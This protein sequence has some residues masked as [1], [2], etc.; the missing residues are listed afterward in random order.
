[1]PPTTEVL[2]QAKPKNLD[3]NKEAGPR[4]KLFTSLHSNLMYCQNFL[5]I[6]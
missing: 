1:M 4:S 6:E 5:A 2:Q 3:T